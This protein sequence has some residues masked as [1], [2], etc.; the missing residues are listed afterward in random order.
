MNGAE[1]RLHAREMVHLVEIQDA[2]PPQP[3]PVC[4]CSLT[5]LL[6]FF[7]I[8]KFK[9]MVLLFKKN[10]KLSVMSPARKKMKK[11]WLDEK[12][13]KGLAGRGQ[14]LSEPLLRGGGP[15]LDGQKRRWL[16][17]NC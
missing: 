1:R 5:V 9:S 10:T 15:A 7:T 16:E 3:P 11:S 12:K 14:G 2:R 4:A 8:K 6:L 17:E 13:T